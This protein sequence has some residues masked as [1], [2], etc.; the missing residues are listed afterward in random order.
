MKGY[1]LAGAA[2]ILWGLISLFGKLMV[3]YPIDPSVVVAIRAALAFICL[4]VPLLVLRPK[5]LRIGWSDVPFF[6]ALGLFGVAGAYVTY[7][8]ALKNTTVTT[9]VVIGYTYPAMVAAAAALFLGEKLTRVKV[10]AL[11]LAILGCFFVAQGYNMAA[12]QMNLTGILFSLGTA[13]GLTAYNILAKGA[14]T[15]YGPWT[16]AAYGFG[17]GAFWLFIIASPQAVLSAQLTPEAWM[18]MAAWVLI[19]TI[20]GYALYLTAL[21]YIEVSKASIV[22]T[23]EPVSAIVLACVFL[24]ETIAPPQMLGA[25]LVIAA[26]IVLSQPGETRAVGA[27]EGS[28]AAGPEPRPSPT[29]VGVGSQAQAESGLQAD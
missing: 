4:A 21:K 26:V 3:A 8:Y 25:A 19:P 16:L 7:V 5:L 22:C 29:L 27:G 13:I 24:G 17:F 9:A 6:L 10:I 11:V 14:I 18:I 23:L 12:F 2:G 15:R 20:L 28:Q 1:V